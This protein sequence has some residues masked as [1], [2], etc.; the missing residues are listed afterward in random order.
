MSQIT[1]SIENF[2][3]EVIE[4]FVEKAEVLKPELISKIIRTIRWVDV[5]KGKLDWEIKKIDEINNLNEH[6]LG[7]GDSI[8]I[9][10]GDHQVGY[11]SFK[12]KFVTLDFAS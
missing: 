11:V 4:E 12:I 7:K 5:V 10:F 3:M 6:A 8:C 1:N 9:D 2:K